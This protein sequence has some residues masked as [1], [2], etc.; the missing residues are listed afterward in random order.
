MAL[1]NDDGPSS[2]ED[3]VG[4]D[5]KLL[6]LSEQE[7][8]S[9]EAKSAYAKQWITSEIRLF[10]LNNSSVT[11]DQV[12]S[13][14]CRIVVT[15]PLKR[16]HAMQTLN[17]YYDDIAS[18][19]ANKGHYQRSLQYANRALVARE[20]LFESGIGFVSRA[21]PQARLP[22]I[23]GEPMNSP[24]FSLRARSQYSGADGNVGSP[25]RE[26]WI[27]SDN[28]ESMAILYEELPEG[29]IGWNLYLE[30]GNGQFRSVNSNPISAGTSYLIASSEVTFGS[31]LIE[32]GQKPDYFLRKN[33]SL[34]V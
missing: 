26:F 32:S 2:F 24:A 22:H 34:R 13:S 7:N 21:I 33:R 4:Y 23:K 12:E 8:T 20:M 27:R 18:L 25:S 14:L 29:V 10:I 6:F 9:V 16:W 3:W 15:E 11:T 5:S 19:Q 31:S 28:G 30:D 17:L 1:L